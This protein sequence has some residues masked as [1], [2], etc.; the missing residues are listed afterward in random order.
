MYEFKDSKGDVLRVF[1]KR[2]LIEMDIVK[3]KTDS[4]IHFA[5][6]TIS[7]MQAKADRGKIACIAEEVY[8]TDFGCKEIPLKIG[9]IVY[10]QRFCGISL[11][12]NDKPFK[13]VQAE[14]IYATIYRGKL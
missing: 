7:T 5:D 10:L 3:T 13:I 9:D 2:V 14:D 8:G 11:T 6:N 1:G 4:G 12:I